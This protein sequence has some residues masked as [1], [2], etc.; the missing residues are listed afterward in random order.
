[1]AA[2]TRPVVWAPKASQ[3]LIRIWR[4]F[5]RVASPE[6]ADKLLRDINR[7][8]ARLGEF[9]FLGPAREE[10]LPG[11]RSVP[12]HPYTV[13]YRVTDVQVEIVR[14]LHER[15]DFAATLKKDER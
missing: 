4:Y 15:R 13:F 8:A 14:V 3:D 6:V 11:I 1:M 12:A 9:P 7:A 10:V 2:A 5:A